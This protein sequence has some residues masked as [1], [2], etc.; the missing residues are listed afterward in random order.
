M[1]NDRQEIIEKQHLLNHKGIT[2]TVAGIKIDDY[3]W[4]GM[5]ANVE[6]FVKSCQVCIKF[7]NRER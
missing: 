6:R 7:N 4:R 1:K 3:I 2:S 5:D